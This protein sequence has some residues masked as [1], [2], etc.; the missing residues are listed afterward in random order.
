[1]SRKTPRQTFRGVAS[2]LA[3]TGRRFYARGWALGTSGNFSAVVSRRPFRLA[4]TGSGVSKRKLGSSDIVQ[5]DSR[6]GAVGRQ[7]IKPSAETFL[8]LEIARRSHAGAVLHTHSVWSTMLSDR[9]AAAGG[10]DIEGYEMLKGLAGVVTHEH[11]E[12][13]PI[14]ENDQDMRRLAG[15]VGETLT[16]HEGTHAILLR[17]H[18][19]YVWGGTLA[20]AE[21]HV[22]ILEF[23]FEVIGRDLIPASGVSHGTPPNS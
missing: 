2:T 16:R 12:W 20:E 14:L 9:Y 10:L 3:K 6:G 8:H 7:T 22:E 11:R 18:G 15:L 21:R 23:L 5:C 17:R 13:I 19:L 4:I 1:V